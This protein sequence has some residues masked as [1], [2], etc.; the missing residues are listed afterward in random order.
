M[1]LNKEDDL[2]LPAKSYGDRELTDKQ[3]A[4]LEFLPE[5]HYRPL[6]AAK[7]AGYVNPRQAVKSVRKEITEQ[8][9][10]RLATDAL[11][12]AGLLREVMRTEKPIPLIK[13]KIA[14]A[15]SVLDRAG[16]AKK[17]V[18]DVNHKAVGGVFVLPTKKEI[19]IDASYDEI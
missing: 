7:L 6:E 14:V 17:D 10:E 2:L 8:V 18:I 4:L 19:V 5:A 1:V 13:E 11:E 15:N 9:E 12:A 3:I 16:H